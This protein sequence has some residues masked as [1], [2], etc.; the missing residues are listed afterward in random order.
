MLDLQRASAGSGKTFALAR[1]Y[2]RFFISILPP[3][4]ERRRLRTEAEMED[5]LGRIL[6]MTF[7]NKAT[8]EMQQR[9]VEKLDALAMY[10][11][12]KKAPDYMDVFV[13]EFD[14]R[15]EKIAEVCGKALRI[16][17]N[18]YSRFN[19]S[20]ID[21]FF[22]Q[23]LR[24]FAFESGYSDTYQVELES[25]YVSR[26]G[27]D[28]TFDEIDSG[29][30]DPDVKEAKEWLDKIMNNE[31][32]SKWNIFQKSE[33]SSWGKKTP[34]A[35]L[36]SAFR[37]MDNETFRKNK[38]EIVDYL[39]NDD[40][41]MQLYK[42]MEAKYRRGVKPKF[43][44]LTDAAARLRSLLSPDLLLSG[45]GDKG[46]FLS[47]LNK[48]SDFKW[49]VVPGVTLREIDGGFL[50]K[51]SI[52]SLWK[53]NPAEWEERVRAYE[54][55][56]EKYSEWLTAVS[57]PDFKL[58]ESLRVSFPFLGLLKMVSRKRE[59]FLMENNSVELGDTAML[60]S[61]IIGPTDTPFV[62]ERMGTYLDHL[63]IDEFQDTSLLQWVNMKP[64]LDES[65][66]RGNDNLIIGDAKQSIYRFRNAEPKLISQIVPDQYGGNARQLGDSPKENTN[67]RS[68]LKV[69][70][71]NNG[72]F[73]YVVSTMPDYVGERGPEVKKLFGNLYSNVG[74]RA[75]Y[76]DGGYV[77]V[78][79]YPDPRSG[80]GKKS[81][82]KED[83]AG[84]PEDGDAR[85]NA[86]DEVLNIVLDALSRG[87]S[88]RDIAILTRTTDRGVK[89]IER[90]REYNNHRSADM[91]LLEFVSEESLLISNSESVR[92]IIVVLET[93]A[94]GSRPEK[95]ESEPD[96]GSGVRKPP[97]AGNIFDL[98][99]NLLMFRQ[100]HPDYTVAE[101]MEQ[102]TGMEADNRALVEMLEE[103]QILAL[104]ALVESIIE[105]FIPEKMRRR[106]AIFLAAFQDC[107]LEY[108]EGHPSDLPSFMSWWSR[109]GKSR[110]ISSPEDVDAIQL[111][112]IHKSKGLEFPVVIVPEP[113]T[114]NG[115][116]G[117][118][119]AGKDWR[120]VSRDDLD[121]KDQ[122][123]KDRMPPWIPVNITSDL[124]GTALASVLHESYNLETMDHLNMAYVAMT[125]ASNELYVMTLRRSGKYKE[126]PFRTL[127]ALI[128]CYAESSAESS[129]GGVTLTERGDIATVEYGAKP[130]VKVVRDKGKEKEK[131]PP[132]VMT[133]YRSEYYPDCVKI[134]NADL[135]G[136]KDAEDYDVDTDSDPRS[137]GNVCHAIMERVV[138]ASDLKNAVARAMA[139]GLLRPNETY[140]HELETHLR[141]GGEEVSH[142]FGGGALRVICERP[143][144]NNKDTLRRPDRIMIW[145]DGT[146]DVVDYKFG[147][148]DHTGKYARQV[149]RYV[150]YLRKTGR[151]RF[152]RGWLWYVF[153]DKVEMAAY[154]TDPEKMS[155][156]PSKQ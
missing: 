15:S 51:K 94:R 141:N 125:R 91:P 53:E 20:T 108:C 12:A 149:W 47:A 46:V 64:L 22:Q 66:S 112:T 153:R 7:T 147:E 18:D 30:T 39:Q 124:E 130:A 103:M 126:N 76:R 6:A 78:Y 19:V 99:C 140:V 69:V 117:D 86:D 115:C 155:R 56:Y 29:V 31:E 102:F 111:M 82:S 148:I 11:P 37:R 70:E 122:T 150:D 109:A 68:D 92:R 96:D 93:I 24:T 4:E 119:V 75:H 81:G 120:W 59:E 101:C 41:L 110:A 79:L 139:L 154:S 72:F 8:G 114:S 23:V 14:V 85:F 152:I 84:L 33:N 143:V 146:A 74:Q 50:E 87:Y 52:K 26:R 83:P 144:L 142:W 3:G 10:D 95:G 57:D 127:G 89:V 104:P 106:D 25:D 44:S 43:K 36:L 145:P 77:C 116:F 9:I 137:M 40:S 138:V 88:L 156:F 98:R 136:Y 63:L 67:W 45:R 54:A 132:L 71:W 113:I 16:L 60:L 34:Y 38:K 133:D 134:R 13:K 27:L 61:T 123:I 105:H 90:L 49:N 35:E 73:E 5:G 107:V 151:F 28:A 131:V 128:E 100:L 80:S 65:M 21:S 17:L 97:K 121:I 42:D 62:Y 48:I 32:G 129:E 118:S 135:P 1:Y 55:M 58:W 2:I